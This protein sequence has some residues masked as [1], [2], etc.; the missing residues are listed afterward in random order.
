M[1]NNINSIKRKSLNGKTPFEMMEFLYTEDL[2]T[3][4]GLAPVPDND[5]TLKPRIVK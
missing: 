2:I 5:V 4:L 3:N 1:T